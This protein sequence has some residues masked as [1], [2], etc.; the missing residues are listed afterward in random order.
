M[1]KGK[2][3]GSRELKFSIPQELWK[4]VEIS[5]THFLNS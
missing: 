3:I 5:R 2:Q 4:L 1:T